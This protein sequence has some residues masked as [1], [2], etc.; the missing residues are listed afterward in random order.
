MSYSISIPSDKR[1][2]QID[3]SQSGGVLKITVKQ[4]NAPDIQI[5]VSVTSDTLWDVGN[6]LR[7]LAS[8]MA[9]YESDN[10]TD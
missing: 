8:D 4:I 1:V 5:D 10:E 7:S 6:L 2:Q 9:D 3:F